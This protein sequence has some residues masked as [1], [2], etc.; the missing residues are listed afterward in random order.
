MVPI[1][2]SPHAANRIMKE[3]RRPVFKTRIITI[4]MAGNS[5]AA[6]LENLRCFEILYEIK[7]VWNHFNDQALFFNIM[8]SLLYEHFNDHLIIS[9]NCYFDGI[10]QPITFWDFPLLLSLSQSNLSKPFGNTAMLH[11]DLC[12]LFE[13]GVQLFKPIT[14][15]VLVSIKY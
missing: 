13:W 2:D 14:D 3:I 1:S 10:I 7:M 8:A 9:C 11:G 4:R 5:I 6:K 15:L 12:S